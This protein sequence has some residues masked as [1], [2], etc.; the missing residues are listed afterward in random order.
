M[1]G[2]DNE[3]PMRTSEGRGLKRLPSEY[4]R[5]TYFSTQPMERTPSPAMMAASFEMMNAENTLLYS[6]DYPHWD[7]DVPSV[8]YDL[9]LLSE[10]GKRNILGDNA[11][12]SSGS[13][14]VRASRNPPV[15]HV[16][17][18]PVPSRSCPRCPDRRDPQ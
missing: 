8:V 1:Q 7:F 13:P 9:P 3:Y 15:T 6:S 11:R 4:M 16:P 18:S 10:Q 14:R 5:E 17:A 2:L 12:G